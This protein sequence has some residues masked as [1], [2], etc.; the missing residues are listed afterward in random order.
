MDIFSGC[1]GLT[2]GMEQTGVVETKW[3]IEYMPSA[4]KSFAQNHPQCKV[5]NQCT[6]L[7]LERAI[8]QHTR[9]EGLDH[10]KDIRGLA[11]VPD[12]P[13]PGE[14]DFI[15][16]GP[17]CQGFSRA[18]R[19]PKADDIKTS[20]IAN[21][22]SYVDFYRPHIFLLENVRGLLQYRLNGGVTA[23]QT[24][25]NGGVMRWVCLSLFCVV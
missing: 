1:G 20:M 13:A 15:Y 5:Y 22:L 19:F 14:V 17:P 10:L 18:N 11:W 3:A 12:M 23:G 25:I 24:K 7:L 2:E 16:C 6:N 4:A 8:A 21:S 9:A